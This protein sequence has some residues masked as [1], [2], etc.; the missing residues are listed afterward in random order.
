MRV[1]HM[2]FK[3]TTLERFIVFADLHA[4]RGNTKIFM[5]WLYQNTTSSEKYIT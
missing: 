2:A 1:S 3:Y 5:K 4:K